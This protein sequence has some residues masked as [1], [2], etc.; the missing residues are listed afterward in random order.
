MPRTILV[1]GATGYVGGLLTKALKGDVRTMSRGG[2]D[3]AVKGDVV[4]GE[5]LDEALEGVDVAYYLIHA[6][7]QKGDFAERD[8][9][10][11]WTRRRSRSR[12]GTSWGR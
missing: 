12:R 8:R 9:R 7:G 5:G 11:G 10:G 4:S 6:M 1:T 3:G 2:K